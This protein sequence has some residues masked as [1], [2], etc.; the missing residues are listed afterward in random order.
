MATVTGL[1]ADRM[2]AIEA[3]SVVDGDVVGDNLILTQHGGTQIN[4]GS[5]RG[6]QGDP[7]PVGQDLS[8]ISALPVLTVGQAGQIRAGRQLT[9]A[10][11]TN[12]G[13]SAP[14]GLW[15]LSDLTDAS[16]NGR[17][18]LNKGAVPL[19]VG[20]NGLP[21]TAA[22]FVGNTG[23]ALYIPDTGANDPFRMRTGSYGCWFKTTRQLTEQILMSRNLNA[24]NQRSWYVELPG[25]G[26]TLT[27][28]VS[29][30]G[31]NGSLVNGVTNV[32]DD[33]WHFVVVTYDGTRQAMYIDGNL[34]GS[35]RYHGIFH[36]AA[37]PFNIGAVNADAATATGAPWSGWIDEAFVTG[38][39]LTEEQVRVL[40]CAK[41]PHTLAAVP[42]RVALTVRRRRRGAALTVAD[43]PTPP[44]RLHNFSGGSL[45]DEGTLGVTLTNTGVISTTGADGTPNNGVNFNNS[46]FLESTDAGLPQLASSRSYGAWF[47]SVNSASYQTLIGWGVGL[48]RMG[49][50]GF[51]EAWCA[52][53][54]ITAKKVCND[55]KWH[56][57][58]T[59]VDSAATDGAKQKVYIDGQLIAASATIDTLGAL[60]GKFSIGCDASQN[61]RV[62]GQMDSVFVCSGALTGEDVRKIY[63]KGTQ[64]MGPSPKNV[65]DHVEIMD[66]ANI[67]ATFDTLEA[68]HLID[69]TVA[70]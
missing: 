19:A 39:S 17:S 68:Q 61:Y 55:G 32:T 59:V 46:A 27:C 40:Y 56:H 52:S 26:N 14:I 44:L 66:A 63:N 16:G 34:E 69:L 60:T 28:L 49:P 54:G 35:V 15:N 38:D 47:K 1:T 65:G 29:N 21:N 24:G 18:L 70:A 13:L 58:V 62:V 33:Q 2:L 25:S 30:D 45:G 42:R 48:T 23:Q 4:A 57:F 11:F 51:L 5:V 10:D 37:A 36:P 43:F 8:V 3:A 31:T 22:R 7:G 64:G 41:L 9:A 6:P 67:L 12:L 50:D 53:A 20:I